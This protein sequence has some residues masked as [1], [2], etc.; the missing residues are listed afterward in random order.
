MGIIKG[1]STF[2]GVIPFTELYERLLNLGRIDSPNNSDYAKGIINDAYTRTLPR[3][4]DWQMIVSDGNF[5]TVASY[6]TGTVSV[7]AGSTAVTG[8]GTTFTAAMTVDDGYKIKFSGNR[9]D[10]KS[11]V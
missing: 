9:E 3:V 4:E 7:T 8:V 6:N 5:Q 10:R 11:V 2:I 1:T